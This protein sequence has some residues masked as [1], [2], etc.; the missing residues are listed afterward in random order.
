MKSMDGSQN[1]KRNEEPSRPLKKIYVKTK[2]LVYAKRN[3]RNS[4]WIRSS[5][6]GNGKA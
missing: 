6:Y 1:M 4:W 2:K 5:I 3:P